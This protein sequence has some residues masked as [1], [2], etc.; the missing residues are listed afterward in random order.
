MPTPIPLPLGLTDAT[1]IDEST[2]ADLLERQ[3]D[4]AWR[5]CLEVFP[6]LPRPG[7]WMDL[8]GKSAGQAHFGRGG[9]RFNALL[10]RENPRRF[11]LEVV[12]HEMA[13]WLVR[14]LENG[15]RF[16]PHGP[17]WQ[18]VMRQLFG[19]EPKVTHDFDTCRASP[20]PYRYRCVCREHVFS[21]R[22]H[23][24]VLKGRRYRCRHCGEHLVQAPL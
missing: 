20:A 22:R 16:R 9:L 24:L 5:R 10:Y 15:E 17:E 21:V 14:H 23:R 1:S 3:I 18:T 13:H 4:V 19:L 8:K 12:P 2:L 7:V 11:L 6:G